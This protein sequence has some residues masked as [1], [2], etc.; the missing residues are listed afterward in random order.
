MKTKSLLKRPRTRS[1]IGAL[2]CATTI[3]PM[4]NIPPVSPRGRD[5]F[6]LIHSDPSCPA[7]RSLAPSR[8]PCTQSVEWV[9][10][11]VKLD[12]SRFLQDA[13]VS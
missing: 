11:L 7:S 10:N 8:L 9:Q 2:G 12:I 3:N 13:D 4:F 1:L 6:L 5:F